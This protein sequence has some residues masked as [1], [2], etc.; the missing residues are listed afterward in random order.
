MPPKRA[1]KRAADHDA[2]DEPDTKAVCTGACTHAALAGLVFAIDV[3]AGQLKGTQA[4]LKEVMAMAG[5]KFESTVCAGVTHLIATQ[6]N[7]DNDSAKVKKAK[8]LGAFVVSENF[9]HDSLAVNK[10]MDESSYIIGPSSAETKAAE[11]STKTPAL[12]S[13]AVSTSTSEPAPASSASSAPAPSASAS[14]AS[15]SSASASSASSA[16]VSASSAAAAA[17]AAAMYKPINH[18]KTWIKYESLLILNRDDVT[19]SDSIY[20]F[21]M[22]DTMIE[23][24]SGK[25]FAQG[26]SDWKW[27]NDS[28]APKLKQLHAE[29][30]KLVIITNQSGING[31]SGYDSTKERDIC[32]KI[33]DVIAAVGVPMLALVATSDDRFRKPQTDTWDVLVYALNGGLFD[34]SKSMFIGDAAGRAAA[35][36]GKKTT[37]KDFSCSDRK[38][39][40]NVGVAFQTPEEFFLGDKP[41]PFDWG[42]PDP[43]TLLSSKPSLFTDGTNGPVASKTQ[44]LVLMCGFPASG[45]S[46]FSKKH[47]VPFGYVHVNRD[48]LKTKEKCFKIAEESLAAGKSVVVDNTNPDRESRM[49]YVGLAKTY[50]VPARCFWM[51]ASE[52]MAHHLNYFRENITGGASPHVPGIGYNVFKKGYSD[53][54][55]TEGFTEI[56]KVNFVPEFASEADKIAFEKM[57]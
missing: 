51:Q 16:S 1:T 57:Y 27:L 10:K 15:A 17:A 19:N 38:F 28:V 5:A 39:A 43:K 45:K 29:G 31:K 56:K 22:D 13:T 33:E 47:F 2:A 37:K 30:K 32:G 55:L 41:A 52:E 23:T 6:E 7:V 34:K 24:K 54:Q 3:R 11:V 40:Y 21:D 25:V 44:E 53:P 14:S 36:D 48:T 8:E 49:N 20:A 9:I 35:W 50:G 18:S 12:A 46:T 42:C 4:K 26:R